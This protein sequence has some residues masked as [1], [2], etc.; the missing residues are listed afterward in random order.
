MTKPNPIQAPNLANG[1]KNIVHGFFTREGGHSRGIYAG[2]NV[3]IGS[4]DDRETV[5]RNRQVVADTLMVSPENLLTV[6]QV[7]SANV[8]QVDKAWSGEDRPEVDG[9]VTSKPGIAIG[10]LS[11]DCGPV[12]FCDAEAGVVGA[13]HA[14][15]KGAT[16]G[17]LEN[18]V[19]KMEEL[20]ARRE[21]IQAVLGP[22]ISARNYEVGPEFVD[23]LQ[24]LGSINDTYLSASRNADHA[25][26]DLPA[27]IVDRLRNSGVQAEWTGQCTY[28]H[29]NRFFSYRRTTHRHEADYGRQISAIS[30]KSDNSGA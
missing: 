27:Y 7:H 30:I 20:G 26:F 23:M 4:K 21:T 10:V 28:Q 13:A 19:L 25:M 2:L 9:M 14:G 22:T 24:G 18:T 11:A 16:G 15:W 1:T 17:V 8:I 12:L 3:G 29:E 5:L 6:Y